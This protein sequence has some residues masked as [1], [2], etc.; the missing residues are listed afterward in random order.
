MCKRKLFQ[1]FFFFLL[2]PCS[3]MALAAPSD[4]FD[5]GMESFSQADYSKALEHFKRAEKAGL[6]DPQ[7]YYNL[8]SVYYKLKQ[9]NLSKRY[10]EK[11]AGNKSLGFQAHYNLALIEHKLGHKNDAIALFE[12]SVQITDDARLKALANKQIN[13]LGG[14]KPKTWF[15]FVS[16]G[17]GYDS[18]IAHL[19]SSAASSESGSFF[20]L[21]GYTEWELYKDSANSLHTSATFLSKDYRNSNNFDLDSIALGAE[22]R[23]KINRW[24][25]SYAFELGQSTFSGLDY[26]AQ[27][28]LIFDAKTKLS[29]EK[30]IRF[31]LRHEDISSRSNQFDFLEGVRT[32]LKSGYKLK[33]L[34]QEYQYNYRL[35]LNDRLD[36]ATQNFSPT[37]H[38]IGFRYLNKLTRQLK[39]GLRVN[40]RVSGYQATASQNRTD[41]RSRIRLESK[42]QLNTNW[43]ISTELLF[44]RNKSSEKSFEYDNHMA[45]ISMQALF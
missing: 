3:M 23:Q 29:S 18:N 28:G 32:T 25:L 7:I 19:P 1:I 34:Q 41:K 39:A 26:L 6:K 5:A 10:F 17:Y 37:R 43:T 4:D 13:T 11:L 21:I 36:T 8:G 14:I 20:Q 2:W 12:K 44:S 38:L 9:Y 16:P 15:A 27:T 35:E 30:E 33:I 40:F 45:T 24:N 22:Y 42:Y 31:R